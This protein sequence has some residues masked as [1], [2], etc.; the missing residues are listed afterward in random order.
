MYSEITASSL[1]RVDLGGDVLYNPWTSYSI[2]KAGYIIHNALRSARKDLECAIHT[3]TIDGVAVS[4]MKRGLLPFTQTAMRFR[5]VPYHHHEAV[6]LSK[7]ERGRLIADMADADVMVLRNHGLLAAGPTVQEAFNNIYRLQ[8]ACAI[9]LKAM[10]ANTELIVPS[11]PIIASTNDQ[12]SVQSCADHPGE[13]K[14][15]GI[16]EWAALIRM[17]DRKDDSY[18]Q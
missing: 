6:A 2:S 13:R 7:G 5:Q 8:R 16:T 12:L 3:H 1:L 9:Q 18:K 4:T 17:L 10:A 11:E 15:Y 14:A